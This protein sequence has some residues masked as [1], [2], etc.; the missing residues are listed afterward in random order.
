MFLLV[1]AHLDCGGQCPESHKIVV[2]VA[3]CKYMYISLDFPMLH[4]SVFPNP[5]DTFT[6]HVNP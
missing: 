6:F 2:V 1:P 3:D 4:R 5:N